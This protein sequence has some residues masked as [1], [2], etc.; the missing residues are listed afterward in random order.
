VLPLGSPIKSNDGKTDIHEIPLKK[1][2]N[3]IVGLGAVNCDPEIWGEDAHE[4]KPERWVGK[5]LEQVASVRL[6]G[7]YSGM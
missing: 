7:V 4:W 2:T 1:N 5:K 3:V 6:P